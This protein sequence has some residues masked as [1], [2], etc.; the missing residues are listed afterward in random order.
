M[1][2]ISVTGYFIMVSHTVC[3]D[4]H[5]YDDIPLFTTRMLLKD[6]IGEGYE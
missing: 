4:I 6:R 5:N 1:D 3:G 2:Y